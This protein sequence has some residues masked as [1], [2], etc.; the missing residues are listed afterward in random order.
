MTASLTVTII[1]RNAER[2]IDRALRSVREQGDWPILLVDDASTD[3]T[4]ERATAVRGVAV[5]ASESHLGPGGARALAVARLETPFGVWLDADDALMPGRLERMRAA[6]ERRDVDLVAD[7]AD[8]IDCETG[9]ATAHLPVPEFLG[10]GSALFRL[11]ER[12]WLPSLHVG[13]ARDLV[14]EIG[15]DPALSCCEDYDLLR[16]ALMAGARVGLMRSRGYRYTDRPGSISRD[17]A[18]TRAASARLYAKQP[19]DTVHGFLR[20]QGVSDV[21][22]AWITAS[23]ALFGQDHAAAR[24]WAAALVESDALSPVYGQP[25][26]RLARFV[27]GACALA[28]G[29]AVEAFDVF[30]ELQAETAAPEAANNAGVAAARR[31]DHGRARALLGAAL[32]AKPGDRDAAVNVARLDAGA[33]DGFAVTSHPLRRAPSRDAY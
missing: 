3:A 18:A 27:L 7:E 15:Y 28:I 11:L 17:I 22:A 26:G 13:Y 24:A 30:T 20:A 8:L 32:S 2:S 25:Y 12:N 16:R 4:V 5:I 14:Q 19:A 23:G 10:D 31:G 6:L 9:E 1:A 33:T 29:D 21:E